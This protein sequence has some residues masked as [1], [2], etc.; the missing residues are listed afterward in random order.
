MQ[1]AIYVPIFGPFGDARMV[2]ELA[3]MTEQAGWDGF[4]IWDQLTGFGAENAE[5]TGADNVV[6]TQVALT[7]IALATQHVRFG[8]LITPLARRRPAKY[9][10][11][12]LSLDRLSHGRL[13][14]GVGLGASPEEFEDLGDSGDAKVRAAML[15]ESLEVITGLWSQHP[16]SFSG[17]HY[18][19]ENA[20]FLP[21]PVQK[22]RIPIW[23]AGTWPNK[24]PFRR[25]ARWDGVFPMW[26]EAQGSEM[27][28][29]EEYARLIAFIK[30]ERRSDA[31]FDVVCAGATPTDLHHANAIVKPYAEVGATWWVENVSPWGYGGIAPDGSWQVDAMRERITAGPPKP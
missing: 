18:H 25:A 29:P 30:S 13:I 11:E 31:P 3:R 7:A 27:M 8:A 23:T 4:F 14:C 1:F 9:A 26:A 17:Q 5:E 12:A 24:A 19:V 20:L 2:S 16:F 6:D 21:A 28:P 10:R 15:D 22:P